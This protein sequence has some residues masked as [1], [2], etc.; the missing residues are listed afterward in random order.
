AVL[1]AFEKLWESG[2]DC[3]L[4]ISGRPGWMV[5]DLI[6]RLRSHPQ[7]GNNLFWFD[8]SSDELLEELYQACTA[9]I[10]ASRGEGFGLPLVEAAQRGLPIIARDLAVFREVAGAHAYYFSDD[11]ALAAALARWM[12]LF[13]EDRHPRPEDLPRLT[14]QAS[15]AQ[16]KRV[17]LQT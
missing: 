13:R 8:D 6:A 1:A 10:A 3:L 12:D 4:V 17:L 2:H 7:L 14:W 9:L 15:A 11:S 5:D 16:V